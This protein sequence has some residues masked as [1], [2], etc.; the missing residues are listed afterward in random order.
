MTDSDG[1]MADDLRRLINDASKLG[2][3]YDGRTDSGHVVLLHDS[4]GRYVTSGTASD[5]RA[6][7]N[8]LRD[9]ERLSGRKLPR[10]KAGKFRF[11]KTT[12]LDLKRSVEEVRSANTVD[13]LLARADRIRD[14]F[15]RLTVQVS[16]A[17]AEKARELLGEFEDVRDELA[18]HHRVIEPIF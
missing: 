3:K 10:Q 12:R 4:V 6:Y 11:K 1:S 7:Q 2:F 17:N 16:R 5:W 13:D 8:A 14:N 18:S 9:M 15:R